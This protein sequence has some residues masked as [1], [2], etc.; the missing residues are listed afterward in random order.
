MDGTY[1]LNIVVD[2]GETEGLFRPDHLQRIEALQAY[3]EQFPAIRGSTSVVDYIK[4]MHK[5]VNENRAEY[6]SIPDDEFL[7]AQLFLLYSTTGNPDDFEEEIDTGYSQ[8]NIRFN[9]HVADYQLLTEIIPHIQ[10][11]VATEFNTKEIQARL[12]GLLETELTVATSSSKTQKAEFVLTPEIGLDLTAATRLT[13]ITRFRGDIA[14]NLETGTPAQHNRDSLSKQL[15][16]GNH[17]G[18]ELREAYI[19][20]E[21]GSTFLR[22]GKQQVVWGQADGLKVLDVINP[23]SFRE[24]ILDDFDESRIP[25]W[26]VNAEIPVAGAFLQLLWIPDQTYDDIPE[27]GAAFAFTSPQ[28][29]PELPADVPI[30]GSTFHKPNRLF[31]DSDVAAKLTWFINGWDL[32][33]NYVYHYSDRPAVRRKTSPAGISIEQS[34]ERTHLLG[35]TFSNVFGDLTLRGELGYSSDRFYLASTLADADGL[36]HSGE[37]SYVLGL[38]YQGWTDW[39]ISTQIFQSIVTDPAPALIR[40]EV[41]TTIT[42]LVQRDFFND[43]IQA[44]TLLIQNL[45]QGDGLLQASLEYEWSTDIR[46]KLGADIFYSNP[47]G[48]FGQ[49]KQQDRVSMNIEVGY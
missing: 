11:Y 6:Y 46:L 25:L 48:L 44:E 1:F 2:T 28:I 29:I 27:K 39:F 15:E 7:I 8:A 26:M 43:S 22:L 3:A 34:Y 12:S 23:Q 21:I 30:T 32:S 38:D 19:D 14:D 49:F 5:S 40:D 42:L 35:G 9:L 16:L 37:F 36:S 47:K 13:L 33:L 31:E 17:L 20:T 24:F 18:G 41:D 10:R 4:Q 45:N